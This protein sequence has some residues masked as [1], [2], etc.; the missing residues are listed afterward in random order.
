MLKGFNKSDSDE[1]QQLAPTLAEAAAAHLQFVEQQQQQELAELRVV[2]QHQQHQHQQELADI[3][4]AM[5]SMTAQ[6][7][8]VLQQHQ[9]QS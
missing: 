1:Q 3:R 9:Q 7:Q 8:C 4:A 5:A 2:V 6:L